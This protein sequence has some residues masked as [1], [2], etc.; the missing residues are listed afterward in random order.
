MKK[1][2]SI[3]LAFLLAFSLAGCT[4][5]QS[6][7][8]DTSPK[9]ALEILTTVWSSYSDD[10]KF[11]AMG[12]DYNN[13]TDNKPGKFD[14]SDTESLRSLL[15]VPED[16]AGL[17]DDAASLIHAMNAN[18]FTGAAFHLSD[19]KTLNTFADSLKESILGNQ[20]M[21]GFPEVLLLA[22][23]GDDYVVSAFVNTDLIN[24]FKTQLT[25]QYPSAVILT[26]ENL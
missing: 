24:Y 1:F 25:D 26:E 21:C 6:S 12:G 17:I 13:M 7:K 10:N 4:K 16:A 5:K 8:E 9:D 19:P 11:Q 2:L 18:T 23:I 20:W 3:L 15:I 22:Q 14:V